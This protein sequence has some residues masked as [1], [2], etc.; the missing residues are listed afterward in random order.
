MYCAGN[1]L[2]AG[3]VLPALESICGILL[4]ILSGYPRTL[5]FGC[6][7]A[8]RNGLGDCAVSPISGH[9]LGPAVPGEDQGA[10]LVGLV[11][12]GRVQDTGVG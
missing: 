12:V 9:G 8:L 10:A 2:Y 6:G 7:I 5:V 4:E 11:A 3:G 1:W